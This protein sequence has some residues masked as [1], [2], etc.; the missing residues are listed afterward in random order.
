MKNIA[1]M[2]T[3]L[4]LQN[5]NFTKEGIIRYKNTIKDYSQTLFETSIALGKRE[6]PDTLEVTQTHVRDAAI[7]LQK[8]P[9]AN[10]LMSIL[11]QSLEYICA[12][13]AGLGSGKLDHSWGIL[14]FGGSLALGVILFV[15]RQVNE[16]KS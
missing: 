8:K 15:V 14:L 10:S 2:K 13:S 7:S 6:N 9:R 4:E 16:G 11:G 1:F 3:E 12:I 5:N